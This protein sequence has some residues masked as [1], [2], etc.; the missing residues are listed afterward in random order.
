MDRYSFA[1]GRSRRVTP[2]QGLEHVVETLGPGWPVETRSSSSSLG[3]GGATSSSRERMALANACLNVRPIAITSPTDFMC[4]VR[5]DS[6]PGN[7]S[8]AKRGHL[9]T[10]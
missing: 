4:V 3:E 9:T 1:R 6:A 5:S 10:Q 2:A 7:F 8:K